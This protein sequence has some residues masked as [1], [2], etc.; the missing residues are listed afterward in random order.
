MQRLAAVLALPLVL[1]ATSA[2]AQQVKTVETGKIWSAYTVP[3]KG[4]LTCYLVG[5][6]AKS[7]PSSLPRS[8]VDAM[9]SHRVAEK[10]Y[11]V[12]TFNLG[13]AAKKDAKAELVVDG[14]KYNLFVD[15]DAAWTA[16]AAT[17]KAV[18]EALAHGKSA[19]LKAASARGTATTDT[20]D[21][22]GFGQA[23]KAIDAVCKVK[24]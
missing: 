5:S 16:S 23:L 10:A 13:Y 2:L 17:D 7:E 15:N 9:V 22:S 19:T 20:Y 11:Y 12:V 4:G 1:V 3:E 6:P 14:K 18:T 21:L 24:Q 8:R